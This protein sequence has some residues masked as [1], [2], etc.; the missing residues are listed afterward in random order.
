MMSFQIKVKSNS[1]QF[2]RFIESVHKKQVPFAT[3][4]ALNKT[5]KDV[6]KKIIDKT[7]P[8]AFRLKKKS[9]PKQVI[10][11]KFSNKRK[12]IATI[13]NVRGKAIN[14][15]NWHAEGGIKKPK[16]STY[17]AIPSRQLVGRYHAKKIGKH[18]MPLAILNSTDS[19]GNKR[20]FVQNFKGKKAIF[21]RKTLKPY[22]I[23]LFYFLKPIAKIRQTLDFYEDARKVAEKVYDKHFTEAFLKAIRTA[24]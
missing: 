3:S 13:G 2:G 12:L 24:K 8:E 7:F 6:R 21:Q 4:V 16:T 9:F 20:G 22:P 15:L 14:F 11:I 17:I 18:R 1:R 23:S 5:A 10:F 19:R